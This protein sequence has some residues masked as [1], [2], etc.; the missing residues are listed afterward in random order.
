[1]KH[2]KEHKGVLTRL[3]KVLLADGEKAPALVVLSAIMPYAEQYERPTH[4]SRYKDDYIEVKV[5][6][7]ADRAAELLDPSYPDTPN[8]SAVFSPRG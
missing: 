1:M 5:A 4:I 2:Y 7:D 3:D 6:K 8:L